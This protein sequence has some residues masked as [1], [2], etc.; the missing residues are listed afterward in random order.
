MT[1]RKQPDS[2]AVAT[3]SERKRLRSRQVAVAKG[4]L[5]KNFERELMEAEEDLENT[6]E[7]AAVGMVGW[8][9]WG[10]VVSSPCISRKR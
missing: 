6:L 4:K 9:E 7:V 2:M 8:V 1:S 5:Q 3:S 10:E